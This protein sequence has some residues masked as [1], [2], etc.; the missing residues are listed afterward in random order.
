MFI[1]HVLVLKDGKKHSNLSVFLLYYSKYVLIKVIFIFY[2]LLMFKKIIKTYYKL[3]DEK[4]ENWT[5][6][7]VLIAILIVSASL[8]TKDTDA[9]F[10]TK[11]NILEMEKQAKAQSSIIEINWIKYKIYLQEF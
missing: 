6:V 5:I 8:L 3:L 1:K 4:L 9:V 11:N 10:Y 2:I 7:V